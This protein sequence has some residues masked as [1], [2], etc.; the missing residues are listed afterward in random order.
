LIVS[1]PQ[2]SHRKA[3]FGEAH[4]QGSEIQNGFETLDRRSEKSIGFGCHTDPMF[5]DGRLGID[6]NSTTVS[7]DV[8]EIGTDIVDRFHEEEGPA[9][10]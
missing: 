2:S 4:W 7:L 6:F 9:S 8:L 3:G 1:T 10:M 5:L